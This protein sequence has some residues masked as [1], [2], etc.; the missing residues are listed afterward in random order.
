MEKKQIRKYVLEK[1]REITDEECE[2]KSRVI[3]EKIMEME[4][5]QR[6][7][8]IYVYMDFNH[9]VSTKM[10][11][12]EAWR[13]GKRVA[14]PKVFGEHMRYFYIHS[15]E[16]VSAGYFGVP[17]PVCTDEEAAC[18]DA[19]LI[20]PGV[21]FDAERHRCG[22]GKGFYDKYLSV[23]TEHPTI[24]V[25]FEFQVVDDVSADVYDILPQ[26]LVTEERV[27]G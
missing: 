5:F 13:T 20:V 12:E 10:L 11:I 25:A 21:G 23:H 26:V 8:C 27:I 24:A 19:L 14:A 4:A 18:E 15:Y 22:Y 17:E 3:C 2:A 16:D 1:R 6:A 9:E 7:S